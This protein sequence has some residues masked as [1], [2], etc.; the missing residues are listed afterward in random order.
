MPL[1]FFSDHVQIQECNH[2][3]AG[4]WLR[5][6]QMSQIKW[7]SRKGLDSICMVVIW[8]AMRL[9]YKEREMRTWKEDTEK[10]L[11]S[12]S[13]RSCWG[14]RLIGLGHSRVWARK[15][16]WSVI[17]MPDIAIWDNRRAAVICN[18]NAWEFV[19]EVGWKTKT[20]KSLRI[21]T[22]VVLEK[23]Q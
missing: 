21:M 11:G 23:V 3:K 22:K 14:C 1:G 8:L 15:T 13:C 20:L 7:M 10:V 16:R 9:S 6:I 4:A 12:M 18:D 2:I 5:F 17:R 19:T